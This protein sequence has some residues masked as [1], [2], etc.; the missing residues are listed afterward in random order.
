MSLVPG[1]MMGGPGDIPGGDYC[2][3]TGATTEDAATTTANSTTP[4]SSG[5]S[6]SS[7]SG[8]GGGAGDEA[9]GSAR[10]TPPRPLPSSPSPPTLAPSSAYPTLFPTTP[11]S[12]ESSSGS[13]GGPIVAAMRTPAIADGSSNGEMASA[14]IG[15]KSAKAPSLEL[16]QRVSS[17]GESAAAGERTRQHDSTR[18]EREHLKHKHDE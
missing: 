11:G 9:P 15:S 1:C 7:S 13:S 12:S 17:D 14:K 16:E 5:S 6:S 3:N 10:P 2:Y 8:S 18:H 4:G